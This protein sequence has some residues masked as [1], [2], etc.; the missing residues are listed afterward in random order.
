MVHPAEPCGIVRIHME[1]Y[2]NRTDIRNRKRN[3]IYATVRNRAEPYG[4]V[5]N[6]MPVSEY[7]KELPSDR[8]CSRQTEGARIGQKE[9]VHIRQMAFSP[10]EGGSHETGAHFT[11]K[12]LTLD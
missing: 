4:T 2:R 3:R 10:G 1:P 8:W 11:Q 5:Q 12:K 9:G 6:R 7:R